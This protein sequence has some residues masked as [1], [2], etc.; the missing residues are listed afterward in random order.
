ML[1][2]FLIQGSAQEPYHSLIERNGEN[3]RTVRTCL[4]GENGQDCKHRL[5]FL[6]GGNALVTSTGN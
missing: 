3:L 6:S 2:S 1:Y 5:R 4:A